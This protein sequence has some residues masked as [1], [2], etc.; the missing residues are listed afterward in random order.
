MNRVIPTTKL[1]NFYSLLRDLTTST[2][3]EILNDFSGKKLKR[4]VKI[5]N[6]SKVH[7][8]RYNNVDEPF[9]SNVK[10]GDLPNKVSKIKNTNDITSLLE[11][12]NKTN[13]KVLSNSNFDFRYI[14]REV[15]TIRT[16]RSEFDTG[17]SAKSSG[18]GGL[19]FIGISTN[20]IPI[21]GEIKVNNDEDPFFALIQLLTYLSEL[22]TQNQIKR[23]NKHKLFGINID[24]DSK[25]YLY[26]MFHHNQKLK[27]GWKEIYNKTKLLSDNLKHKIIEVEKIVYLNINDTASNFEITEY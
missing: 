6:E 9:I 10:R 7:F 16:S 2:Q 18:L 17:K 21:L 4:L 19:D 20:N 11:Q 12:K 15:S 1:R 25:F 22:T 8:S 26:I 13:N 5:Y 14:N 27:T 23:I 3:L 24:D